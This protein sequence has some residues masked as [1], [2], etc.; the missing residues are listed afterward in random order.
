MGRKAG[1]T[2]KSHEER[3]A[4]GTPDALDALILQAV[5]SL[6][7]QVDPVPDGLAERVKFATTVHEL[8]AEVAELL[9]HPVHMASARSEQS[10]VETITFT[11]KHLTVMVS[12]APA[13]SARVRIDGW[14]TGGGVRV[15]LRTDEPLRVTSA[16]AEGRF[17]F[18]RVS[19]G[20]AQ[21]VLYRELPDGT[22][23]APVV[24]PAV[25]L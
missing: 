25:V 16:D 18:D 15:E 24:T 2:G 14:V 7:D 17:V 11:S 6:Y 23:E 8:E 1:M 22:E 4:L 3:L 5:R 10:T 12:V 19:K 13:G 21:F 20:I 9:R